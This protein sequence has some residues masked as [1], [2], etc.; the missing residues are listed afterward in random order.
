MKNE[1]KPT[2][3]ICPLCGSPT[4]WEPFDVGHKEEGCNVC[5]TFGDGVFEFGRRVK[6]RIEAMKK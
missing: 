3:N 2:G 6:S 1:H 5:N 4:T